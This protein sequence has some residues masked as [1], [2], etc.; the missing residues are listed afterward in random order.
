MWKRREPEPDGGVGLG[1]ECQAW[2][3][4][5]WAEYRTARGE[6]TPGWAWLNRLAHG[7]ESSLRVM[8]RAPASTTTEGSWDQLRACVADAVIRQ[9]AGSGRSIPDLQQ[10]VLIPIE[11]SL[12]DDDGAGPTRDVEPLIRILAALRHPSAHHPGMK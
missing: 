12:F 3:A 6:D 9:A 5:E 8:T 7:S 2:L 4:G 10:S 1:A 11:L